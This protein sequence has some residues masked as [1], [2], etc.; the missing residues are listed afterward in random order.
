MCVN[1]KHNVYSMCRACGGITTGQEVTDAAILP[2]NKKFLN[3]CVSHYIAR[4]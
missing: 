3:V 1:N 4:L 2:K